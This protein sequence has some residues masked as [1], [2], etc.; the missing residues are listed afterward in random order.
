MIK[1]FAPYHCCRVYGILRVTQAMRALQTG[2][3][4]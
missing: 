3:G 4:G 2:F 1:W